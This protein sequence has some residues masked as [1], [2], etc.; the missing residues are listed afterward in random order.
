M[1][2][3]PVPA[4][5]GLGFRLGE[6]DRRGRER[7]R[8]DHERERGYAQGER[9]RIVGSGSPNTIGPEAIVHT[10]A[11]AL[12]TA[13]TGTALPTWRLRADTA[14]PIRDSVAIVNASG[15]S[16]T[17]SAVVVEVV[18][19]RLDRDVGRA[20]EQPGAQ[21]QRDPLPVAVPP[22]HR[23][24]EPERRGDAGVER[25]ASAVS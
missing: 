19:Q 10:L 24:A 6:P 2:R 1:E 13:M 8:D 14:S 12:V 25:R 16:R 20:P 18:A 7:G 4:L 21:R 5:G 23:G 11:A 15:C 9:G 17:S 22:G 3:V